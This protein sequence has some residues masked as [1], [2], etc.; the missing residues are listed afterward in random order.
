MSE[1]STHADIEG[2]RGPVVVS[3]ELDGYKPLIY[4][5]FT[6]DDDEDLTLVI[7]EDEFDRI[8]LE[9]S[10]HVIENMIE[11]AEM[12]ADMER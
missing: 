7:S 8:Y 4:G 1:Y 3:Y 6:E 2:E 5:I 10:Q 11:S 12:Y 9:V